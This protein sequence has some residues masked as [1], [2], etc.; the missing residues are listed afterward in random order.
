[1]PYL[2]N[3]KAYELQIW[4]I[5][6]GQPPA[7]ATCAMTS[8]VKV[9]PGPLMVSHIVHQIFWMARSTNFKLGIRMDDDDLHQPEVPWP[10]RLKVKVA[11]SRDQSE[12]SWP[13][14]VPVS[15]EASGGIP[16]RPNPVA[17]LLVFI[18]LFSCLFLICIRSCLF[19]LLADAC[20]LIWNLMLQNVFSNHVL[21]CIFVR[22]DAVCNPRDG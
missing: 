16:C 5:D 21:C 13:N 11:R 9:I 7:S 22:G 15:L 4:Y 10:P 20:D 2:P 14:A 12:P 17:T 6:G 8:K 1:M 19:Y 3:G 18:L